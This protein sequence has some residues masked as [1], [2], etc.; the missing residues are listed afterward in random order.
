MFRILPKYKETY[1]KWRA[2]FH[3]RFL[4]KYRFYSDFRAAPNIPAGFCGHSMYP[5]FTRIGRRMYKIKNNTVFAPSSKIPLSPFRFSWNPQMHNGSILNPIPNLSNTGIEIWKVRVRSHLRPY[6]QH[7]RHRGYFCETR[8]SPKTF[9]KNSRTEFHEN[10][11]NGLGAN[12]G[13]QTDGW[14]DGSGVT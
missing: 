3:S 11:I 13:S 9:V 5:N 4:V 12:N 10:S 6:A 8:A 2:K 1:T 7:E 14:R